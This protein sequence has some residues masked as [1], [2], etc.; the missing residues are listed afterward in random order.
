MEFADM[1]GVSSGRA[2]SQLRGLKKIALN[3][4][5]LSALHDACGTFISDPCRGVPK[6]RAN[7]FLS[8]PNLL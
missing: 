5:E 1:L 8:F 7:T 3:V 6:S 2:V 4:Q